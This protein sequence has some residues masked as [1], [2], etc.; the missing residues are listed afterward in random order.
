MVRDDEAT[1]RANRFGEGAD[2]EIDVRL[3][4]RF[5]EN[6]AAV[7][8]E[9]THTVGLVDGDHGAMLP[10]D[11][12][13]FLQGRD[14]A[15]HRLDAFPNDQPPAGLGPAATALVPLPD[16]AVAAADAAGRARR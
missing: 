7:G 2:H 10:G 5:L 9:E 6:A 13:H 4:T 12:D 3:D 15:Q 14:V 8:A 16:A 11:R 1:H